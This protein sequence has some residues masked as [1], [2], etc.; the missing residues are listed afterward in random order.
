MFKSLIGSSNVT[1]FLYNLAI[2]LLIIVISS[3]VLMFLWNRVMV[4][5][6]TVCKP[7]KTLLDAFLLSL[8]ISII[9]GY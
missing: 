2:V 8:T 7:I 3:F 6:V 1:D 5:Y 9:R 4:Q